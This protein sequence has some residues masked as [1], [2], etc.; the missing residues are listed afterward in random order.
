M[1]SFNQ[2]S[3]HLPLCVHVMWWGRGTCGLHFT[4][5]ATHYRASQ[6]SYSPLPTFFLPFT[7]LTAWPSSLSPCPV[8]HRQCSKALSLLL[9]FIPVAV[10]FLPFLL[11][12]PSPSPLLLPLSLSA[13]DVA[14]A[15]LSEFMKL[16][17]SAST[18]SPRLGF[19]LRRILCYCLC[20][21]FFLFLNFL[22]WFLY[23]YWRD[24]KWVVP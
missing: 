21:S 9:I 17:I 23:I 16:P 10:P 12:P 4:G 20:W 13:V 2:L 24:W 1:S 18:P 14:D 19:V 15:C 3:A 22:C 11:S 7:T 5:N 8:I 6:L